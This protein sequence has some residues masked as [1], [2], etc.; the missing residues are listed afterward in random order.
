MGKRIPSVEF[1]QNVFS[2]TTHGFG[3]SEV[4]LVVAGGDLGGL[5]LDGLDLNLLKH[6]NHI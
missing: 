1:F 5:G 6:K 4:D 2:G 3:S